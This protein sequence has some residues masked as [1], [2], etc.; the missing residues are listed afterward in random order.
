MGRE[1]HFKEEEFVLK[2]TGV[3]SLFALKWQLKI[4]Y[5][6]IK[7]VY[8]DDFDPPMWMLRMPGTAIA[9]L[10]IYE[11]SFKF[12]NEWYFISSEHKV[13]LVHIEL[14]NFGKYKYVIFEVENPRAVMIELR[15]KLRKLED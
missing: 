1:V 2:L 10:N 12:G 8:I 3:L 11:G 6:T 9:P 14:E 13:P 4:P 5:K 15:K 7:N